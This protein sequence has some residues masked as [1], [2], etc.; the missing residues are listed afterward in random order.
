MNRPGPGQSIQASDPLTLFHKSREKKAKK[1]VLRIVR[2][3]NDFENKTENRLEGRLFTQKSI[4]R[5]YWNLLTLSLVTK[6]L[7]EKLSVT[8]A[9]L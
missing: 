7:S 4:L 5:D 1:S 2:R 9:K 8:L 3:K 6:L